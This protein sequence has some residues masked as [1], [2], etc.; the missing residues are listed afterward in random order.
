MDSEADLLPY[1][2]T[3]AQAAERGSFTAAAKALGLTQA[4]VSQRIQSLEKTLGKPLF[5][6]PGGK[7]LLTDAGRT[8]HTY[9]QRILE[10]HLEARQE[11]TGRAVPVTGDLLLAA[12]TVPGEH[13]LPSLVPAFRQQFPHIHLRATVGDSQAVLGQVE[14]GEASLGLVGQRSDNPH[15]EF[16]VF[17]RDHVVLVIPAGHVLS[18][19]KKVT[20]RQLAAHPLVLREVGSGLRH[21]VEKSLEKAGKSLADFTVAVELGSNEAVKEALANGVGIAFL[22]AYT[23][24]KEIKSGLL[25]TLPVTDLHCDREMFVVWDKRRVLPIPARKFLHFLQSHPMLDTAP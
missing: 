4:A 9:A 21:C 16:Q 10:L 11:I 14:R 6:R 12:S 2:V 13:L 20:L 17:A 23:V 3:F 24:Q 7:A 19:K 8:L 1:L 5:Q 25:R 22:S 18:K 15:L